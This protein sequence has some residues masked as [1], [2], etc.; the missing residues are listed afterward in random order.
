MPFRQGIEQGAE[1]VMAAH[2]VLPALD[3]APSTPATFSRPILHDLLRDELGFGGLVYTDSMSMDAITKM[4][5]PGEAAVRAVLAGADQVL[6]SP[7]PIAAFNGIK[8]AVASGRIS[9][10]QLDASVERVLRA[11]ASVGL[12]AAARDRSRCRAGRRS[13]GA[14]IRRSRRRRPR[15]RSRSS[16]T[17]AT[18]CRSPFARDAP[19]LYLSVL[20]YPSGWQIAAPS[21]TFIPELKKRWPQVTAIEVSDH[22]P[23]SELESRARDRAALRGD[24]RVGVRASDVRQRPAR[25]VARSSVGCCA[26]SRARRRGRTRRSSTVVL[27]QS[28]TP[29]RACRSCRRCC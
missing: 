17:I 27:R 8:A 13:A 11:K 2:I 26:I 15:A 16:R 6:H 20:D 1:A 12:H 19:V 18:R 25:S 7:D 28:R 10:A 3:P 29:R 5:P 23:L 24:R 22:T 9:Q 21:R 14:R 4:V